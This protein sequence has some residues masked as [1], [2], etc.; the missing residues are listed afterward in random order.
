MTQEQKK[1]VNYLVKEISKNNSDATEELYIT[2]YNVIFCFLKKITYDD[3][4]IL[5]SIDKTFDTVIAKSNKILYTNCYGWILKIAKNQLINIIRRETNRKKFL[6]KEES[7]VYEEDVCEKI[8][9]KNRLNKLSDTD[10]Q[11]L[12]ML[13]VKT[14]NYK[15]VSKLLK[16]SEITIRRH[17]KEILKCLEGEDEER[18]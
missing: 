15:E 4:W 18:D 17:E 5:E 16:I 2:M 12:Y 3:G 10:K 7:F 14:W 9:I 13:Y 8:D 11:I 6:D 1:R